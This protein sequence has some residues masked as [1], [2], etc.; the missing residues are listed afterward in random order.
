MR[1]TEIRAVVDALERAPSIIIPLVREV[2]AD[3]LKRRPKPGKWSAH[4]HACHLAEVNPLFIDR[5][6]LMLREKAPRIRP[7]DPGEAAD[8]DALL[9]VDLDEALDRF[10]RDRARIVERL[11]RLA[12]ADWERTAEHPEYARYSVLIAFRHLSLHDGLHAYR[13]EEVLL[14]RE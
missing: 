6:D 13:I 3:R 4:E 5:L 1:E 8:L 14:A 10:A 12:P 2:P 7:Y 11:R 9:K